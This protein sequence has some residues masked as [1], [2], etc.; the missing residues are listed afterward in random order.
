MTEKLATS[1]RAYSSRLRAMMAD[2]SVRPGRGELADVLA[3]IGSRT[4]PITDAGTRALNEQRG[5]RGW[6]TSRQPRSIPTLAHSG[7]ASHCC[8]ASTSV[9]G[10]RA[11]PSISY[12]GE[13]L[14]Q[15]QHCASR[16]GSFSSR[17]IQAGDMAE[18]V[19][20]GRAVA[21]SVGRHEVRSGRIS[22]IRRST[23]WQE[24]LDACPTIS[25]SPVHRGTS[26]RRAVAI[27][28]ASA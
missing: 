8:A 26:A 25:G 17:E 20:R 28:K 22:Y 23:T 11:T 6:S 18:T 9:I 1:T 5:E 3:R 15:T 4:G 13:P 2:G 19:S 7:W 10:K 12:I 27:Q 16:G 24:C 21:D 14:P